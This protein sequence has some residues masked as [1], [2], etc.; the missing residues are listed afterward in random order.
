MLKHLLS[1]EGSCDL[2]DVRERCFSVDDNSCLHWTA[3]VKPLHVD[4][5]VVANPAVQIIREKFLN[6]T[7]A[8]H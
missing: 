7:H 6:I 4:Q 8:S 5:R 3:Q 1:A 2:S